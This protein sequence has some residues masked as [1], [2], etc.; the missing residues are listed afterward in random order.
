MLGA[1]LVAS[2][3]SGINVLANMGSSIKN[4]GFKVEALCTI[5][6]QYEVCHPQFKG[7]RLVINF[8]TELVVISLDDIQSIKMFDSRRR[9]VLRLG[10]KVGDVDFAVSFRDAYGLR[11][12][13]VRFKNSKSAR[14]FK[15][16][17]DSLELN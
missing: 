17:V 3:L 14:V 7:D 2:S 12:G 13:F 15:A 10:K 5:S 11:T 1:G 6:N 9:E 4:P 8:P 16:F